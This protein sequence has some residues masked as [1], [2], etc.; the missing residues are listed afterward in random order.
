MSR[1]K[2]TFVCQSCGAVSSRWAGKCEA[3]GAWNS[4]VEEAA[5]APLPGGSTVRALGRGRVVVLEGLSGAPDEAPRL[6]VGI[7]EL[8]RVTGGGFVHGSALLLGGDPGIGKSTL[9]IQATAELARADH[10]VVYVSGEE[11]AGQVR[12]RAQRLGL[13]DAPVALAAETCVEDILAT[14]KSGPPPRLV[15]IDSIQTLWTGQVESAPGTVTQVRASAQAMIRYAKTTGACVVLV[16]HVTK[17]GQIAGPRVVEHMVDAVLSFEGDS[18]RD[19]RILRAQKNRFGPTDE[20]GVFAMTGAGLEEVR[21]PSALFLGDREPDAPGAAVFAGLEGSR[22]L[23]VE[24]QALVVPSTLGTPRRAVVGWEGSRL[25]MVLAVLEAR[26]GVRLGGHDVHLAVAGGLKVQEPAADLAVAA[27]LISSMTDAPLPVDAVFFGEI[28]LTGA[29]RPVS[30]PTLRLREAAR[31]GFARAALP[32][33]AE[34]AAREAGLQSVPVATLDAL[35]ARLAARA[36]AARK[37]A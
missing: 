35:V 18:G 37:G 27:A 6:E 33:A 22:P 23:L 14:L 30:H 19:F 17:D 24:I 31:L 20:I 8:D 28:G 10:R 16:G 5:A 7:A 4:I 29:V 25:A 11:A 32:A 15:I 3:C 26:C 21:N 13:S 34:D 1:G 9:L 2:S 12:L 36:E